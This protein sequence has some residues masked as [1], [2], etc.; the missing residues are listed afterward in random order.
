MKGTWR[1][2]SFTGDPEGYVQEGHGDGHLSIGAL[3][4]NLE[5]AHLPW[6]LRNETGPHWANWGGG[7]R[8]LGTFGNSLKEGS[9]YG[10]SLSM[11]ALLGEPGGEGGSFARGPEG[12][13][14][15]ALRMDISPHG[16]S[17]G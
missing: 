8:R 13:E 6:T 15:K 5:G 7:V 3:L 9:G 17:A 10:A 16:G 12:Y 1:E 11:G 4:R 14:R 2:G